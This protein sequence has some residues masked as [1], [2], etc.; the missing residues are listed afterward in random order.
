MRCNKCNHEN[1][2]GVRFCIECGSDLT[3]EKKQLSGIH[4]EQL[5]LKDNEILKLKQ[6]I[7]EI[8]KTKNIEINKLKAQIE[9]TLRLEELEKNH[10]NIRKMWKEFLQLID[11]DYNSAAQIFIASK[12]FPEKKYK[13]ISISS[14]FM[15]FLFSPFMLIYWFFLRLE[16][17]INNLN[18]AFSMWKEYKKKK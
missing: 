4:A 9:N 15:F 13:I 7:E 16:Y 10:E 1:P 3:S 6:D 2:H 18:R 8:N 11:S 5:K 14:Y 17:I 12:L